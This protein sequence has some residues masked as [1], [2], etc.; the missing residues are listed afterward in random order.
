MLNPSPLSQKIQAFQNDQLSEIAVVRELAWAEDLTLINSVQSQ[1]EKVVRQHVRLFEGAAEFEQFQK[2]NPNWSQSLSDIP[3][4][5]QSITGLK[6]LSGLLSDDS[7]AELENLHLEIFSGGNHFEFPD[8]ERF[9]IQWVMDSI[10][11]ESQV[12]KILKDPNHSKAAVAQAFL[13]HEALIIPQVPVRMYFSDI[14]HDGSMPIVVTLQTEDGESLRA[15]ALYTCDDLLEEG[16]ENLKSCVEPGF[17]IFEFRAPGSQIAPGLARMEGLHEMTQGVLVNA[18]C[19]GELF[20]P[21]DTFLACL[22][23]N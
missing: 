10:R 20:L 2:K 6:V 11:L 7:V 13:D 22:S 12:L 3:I 21:W 8:L 1:G 17:E 5:L 15:I 23:G 19:D 14:E 16:F 4:V 9:D 18:F